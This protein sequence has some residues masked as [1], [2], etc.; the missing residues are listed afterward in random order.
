M[1]TIGDIYVFE[2]ALHYRLVKFWKN[3]QISV[4]LARS[5]KLALVKD[6]S[7]DWPHKVER[8]SSAAN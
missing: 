7:A 3:F 2:I 6:S 1:Y 8:L 5:R 4:T